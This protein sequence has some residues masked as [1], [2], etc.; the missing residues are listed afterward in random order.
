MHLHVFSLVG[1]AWVFSQKTVVFH[2]N[3]A[4]FSCL[5]FRERGIEKIGNYRGGEI[6]VGGVGVGVAVSYIHAGIFR[7]QKR[8]LRAGVTRGCKS[9][10]CGGSG[11]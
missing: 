1:I 4:L 7:G 10:L 8:A 6:C 3:S 5:S 11:V 9:A 2:S